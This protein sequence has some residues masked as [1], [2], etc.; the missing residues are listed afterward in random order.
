MAA[1]ITISVREQKETRMKTTQVLSAVVLIGAAGLAIH[2]TQAQQ[3]GVKRTDVLQHDL[4]IPGREVIQARVDFAPEAAFEFHSHPGVEVAYVLEGT[5]EYQLGGKP[6]V[7]LNAGQALFIPA[8]AFHAAKNVGS[9]NAV[10]LAT[11]IVEKGQPL[12]VLAK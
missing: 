9:V 12:V 2:V 7:T 3:S 10:E 5:L 8:G 6:P 4:G 11:Y 1:L